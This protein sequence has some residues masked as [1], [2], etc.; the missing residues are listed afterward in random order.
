M[1]AF[2]DM[3]W[4]GM[5]VKWV[6][7]GPLFIQILT[8]SHQALIIRGTAWN[9]I[10]PDCQTNQTAVGVALRIVIT[11]KIQSIYQQNVSLSMNNPWK[12]L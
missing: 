4:S 3:S 6:E 7:V 12:L 9:Q 1:D 2:E 5:V 11:N 10:R 8:A